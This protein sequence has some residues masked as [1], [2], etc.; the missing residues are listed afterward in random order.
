[1]F[2]ESNPVK[3]VVE[4]IVTPVISS[5]DSDTSVKIQPL[6]EPIE[7]LDPRSLELSPDIVMELSS[8]SIE[9]K[10]L[11]HSLPSSTNL[12]SKGIK[13]SVGGSVDRSV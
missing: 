4:S 3:E 5:I 12:G 10:L 2:D 9:R 11:G 6:N 7:K 8:A 13:I 1:M